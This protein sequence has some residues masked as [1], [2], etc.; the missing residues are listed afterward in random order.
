[1]VHEKPVVLSSCGDSM[2]EGKD[3]RVMLSRMTL[4][5]GTS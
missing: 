5:H 1:M 3:E 4:Y 2:R